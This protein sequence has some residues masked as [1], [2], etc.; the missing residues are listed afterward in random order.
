MK[1]QLKIFRFYLQT[2]STYR[3]CDLN[4]RRT[5]D[6]WVVQTNY[7]LTKFLLYMPVVNALSW[8]TYI[9]KGQKEK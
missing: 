4:G 6:N 8:R 1:I 5:Q 7:D 3:P 2:G 9:C